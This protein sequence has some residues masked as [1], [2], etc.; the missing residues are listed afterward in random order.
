MII[1]SVFIQNFMS[2]KEANLV[3]TD[4]D[5]ITLIEGKCDSAGANS[6]GSGKSAILDAIT[7]CL[8]GKLVRKTKKAKADDVMYRFDTG[9][10]VVVCNL[11]IAG[12]KIVV[13][14]SRSSTGPNF[15]VSGLRKG[16]MGGVQETLEKAIGMNYQTFTS[17][18]MFG[19]GASF[20][21]MTDAERKE[22][23]EEML[24]IDYFL[25]AQ[26]IAD[27][28]A[29]ELEAEIEALT[30]RKDNLKDN[31]IEYT[32]MLK[33][34][35][36]DY[37]NWR[38]DRAEQLLTLMDDSSDSFDEMERMCEEY[39]AA[40]IQ[41]QADLE[42]YTKERNAWE[43]EYAEVEKKSEEHAEVKRKLE[44]QLAEIRGRFKSAEEEL[45]KLDDETH[46]DRCPTCGQRWPQKDEDIKEVVD[47]RKKYQQTVDKW[48][49]ELSGVQRKVNEATVKEEKIEDQ[50]SVILRKEPHDI[51]SREAFLAPYVRYYREARAVH[52]GVLERISDFR[53]SNKNNPHKKIVDDFKKRIKDT[54]NAFE[55]IKTKTEEIEVSAQVARYWATA[56]GRKGLPS[57]LID[58]AI[59]ALNKS[60]E[61]ISR[62]L[63]DGDLYVHFD[64]NGMRGSQSVLNVDVE[65]ADGGEVYDLTSKGEHNR[66]DLTILFALRDLIA[67]RGRH[68]CPMVFVDEVFD[69][70]DETGMENV[71]RLLRKRYGDY[72]IFIISHDSSLKGFVDNII[73]V[74]KKGHRSKIAA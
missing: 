11:D 44:V 39:I 51:K 17:S 43:K 41:Y 47:L 73:T 1:E 23:I 25:N 64:P 59:P 31:V 61:E 2:F 32:E 58:A 46:P 38:E 60:T 50:L 30:L 14:R 65:F 20:C 9:R 53:R 7:W 49:G 28:E 10:T 45:N 70:L 62:I 57:Y 56:F 66:V 19:G 15:T 74:V 48:A 40:K 27:A 67:S 8:Y 69:G 18:V 68:E 13:E 33:S 12:T 21:S 54:E 29:K 3:L 5:G 35:Q 34:A 72:R 6:N 37:K 36:S 24:D 55:E 52:D 42:K 71:I 4:Y 63:T 22:V 26:K 16:T